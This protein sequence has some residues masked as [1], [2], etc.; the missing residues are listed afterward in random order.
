M[1]AVKIRNGFL[2]VNVYLSSRIVAR[3]STRRRRRRRRR[4]IRRLTGHGF[5]SV[6]D[7]RDRECLEIQNQPKSVRICTTRN[8][9]RARA[10]VRPADYFPN[11]NNLRR[12]WREKNESVLDRQTNLCPGA[13]RA[14]TPPAAVKVD[15][16][17][18]VARVHT[19]YRYRPE[20]R[21]S[22]CPDYVRAFW[23]AWTRASERERRAWVTAREPTQYGDRACERGK[24]Y[25]RIY[26]RIS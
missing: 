8:A 7:L 26:P 3:K 22:G 16:G 9:L 21:L 11:Q 19:F 18:Y 15:V 6:L 24:F 12:F 2:Y 10:S 4:D 13:R 23:Y 25:P 5:L 20:R 1:A 14:A 17:N